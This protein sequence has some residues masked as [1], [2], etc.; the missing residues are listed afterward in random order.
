M[1]S[2]KG[3]DNHNK[4]RNE[5]YIQ[6]DFEVLSKNFRLTQVEE[7]I[8]LL[9]IG[10]ELDSEISKLCSQIH[11]NSENLFP[12]FG[13]A[14]SVFPDS[15]WE[16]ISP[17]SSLRFYGLIEIFGN[18][19]IPLVLRPIRITEQI[20]HF[21]LG[22]KY[23]ET[24]LRKILRP[25]NM[26]K[27]QYIVNS[28]KMLIEKITKGWKTTIELE[29]R[30]PVVQLIGKDESSKLLIANEVCKQ[31]NL[32]LMTLSSE[33]FVSKVNDVNTFSQLLNRDSLLF[34]FALYLPMEDLESQLH[35]NA[36]MLI[37]SISI[38]I[39]V[40]TY[41]PWNI[42]DIYI[43]VYK[44]EKKEQKIIWEDSIENQFKE[45]LSNDQLE[46]LITF[47]DFNTENIKNVLDDASLSFKSNGMMQIQ[48]SNKDK[49]NNNN[50]NK[51]DKRKNDIL[52]KEIW[53][54]GKKI[55]KRKVKEFA[56][57]VDSHLVN[58]NDLILPESEKKLLQ[59]IISYMTNYYK[60]LDK[61][62]LFSNSRRGMNAVCL[63]SGPSGTGKTMAAQVIANSLDLELFRL[64][65]SS[66]MSK[67]VG[68]TEKHIRKL[69][70]AAANG[71]VCLLIDECDTLLHKR[72]SGELHDSVERYG[73]SQISYMLQKIE[74]FQGLIILT[75]NMK[76]AIDS[77]FTR[78]ILVQ[79]Q[80]RFPTTNERK[81]IWE[82]LLSSLNIIRH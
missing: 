2:D 45:N 16:V 47:F 49:N 40:G 13:L 56:E 74:E 36:K 54:S 42:G 18:E 23:Y 77:A 28:H 57:Y 8:M 73:N 33:N 9:C 50:N 64:D 52:F 15:T 80:F 81:Q 7:W 58:N 68:Q 78:R 24:L 62:I 4:N 11:K 26:A 20:L 29:K 39:F 32:S 21:C 53:N 5:V 37:E 17:S 63:F 6:S 61:S 69:F 19:S 35:N 34:G 38:P 71:G 30:I 46:K 76:D 44:P 22:I 1:K 75:S 31:Y 59:N 65:L 72:S 43:D 51:K 27:D 25:V 3:E 60:I 70:D 10:I 66:V 14:L 48:K 67:W 79:C 41:N 82:R 55:S 12:T